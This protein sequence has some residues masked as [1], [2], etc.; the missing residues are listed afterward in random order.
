MKKVGK[1]NKRKVN[2]MEGNKR[3]RNVKKVKENGE[4]IGRK[5]ENGMLT[6]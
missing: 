5:R 6:F 2:E 3:P 4:I 1:V